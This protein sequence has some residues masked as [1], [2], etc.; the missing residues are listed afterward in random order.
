MLSGVTTD[1]AGITDHLGSLKMV[2]NTATGAVMQEMR[3]D[4]FGVVIS[5]TNPGFTPFGFAGGLYDGDT[6]LTRFGARDYDAETGRWT[7][8]DPIGFDGGDTNLYG[9]V[10][11]DPVNEVDPEGLFGTESCNYYKQAC[12]ANGGG[13]ECNSQKD[14][15]CNESPKKMGSFAP[16]F[17]CIR[18]CLQEK[19]YAR[20]PYPKACSEE[21]N[22]PVT[23]NIKDH[24]SCWTGCSLNSQNPYDANGPDLPSKDI[25]LY[26]QASQDSKK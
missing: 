23:Q 1:S 9:Y 15:I 10:L 11:Q 14:Y 21:N 20:M 22:M 8:K 16:N 19:H 13:Y 12:Q 24:A 17:N 26:D 3:Y 18:Q 6:K 25:K 7:A 5:D 2:V 4:E